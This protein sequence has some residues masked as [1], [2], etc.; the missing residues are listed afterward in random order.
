MLRSY[1]R[2]GRTSHAPSCTAR[3]PRGRL[4][5]LSSP[6]PPGATFRRRRGT[7]RVRCGRPSARAATR[8]EPRRSFRQIGSAAAVSPSLHRWRRS[9]YGFARAPKSW[10]ACCTAPSWSRWPAKR[11]TLLPSRTAPGARKLPASRP[12]GCPRPSVARSPRPPSRPWEGTACSRRRG[13]QLGRLSASRRATPGR[14]WR[15]RGRTPGRATRRACG[16]RSTSSGPRAPR[17]PPEQRR[18]CSSAPAPSRRSSAPGGPLS[19]TG[20]P[21][22]GGPSSPVSRSAVDPHQTCGAPRSRRSGTAGRRTPWAERRSAA[23]RA[24]LWRPA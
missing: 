17:S 20:R 3:G 5:G 14:G 23:S 11:R 12:D 13:T 7:E 9:S 1:G 6:L 22:N 18:S 4:P 10:T 21:A 24:R 2:C 15:W 16:G 19:S 8:G